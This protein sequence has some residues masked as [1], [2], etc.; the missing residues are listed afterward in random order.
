VAVLSGDAFPCAVGSPVPAASSRKGFVDVDRSAG[1]VENPPLGAGEFG[2]LLKGLLVG[3]LTVRPGLVRRSARRD[4]NQQ[5]RVQSAVRVYETDASRCQG[6]R[7][8]EGTLPGGCWGCTSDMTAPNRRSANLDAPARGM[9]EMDH[10]GNAVLCAARSSGDFRQ[11]YGV[12]TFY[13]G[14]VFRYRPP[15]EC[16]C[17]QRLPF[18]RCWRMNMS[19]GLLR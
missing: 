10:R 6:G 3:R 13:V 18:D 15:I 16:R 1:G 2:P 8:E 4:S 5:K 12:A 14:G 11:E 19:I 7:R 17:C 9:G